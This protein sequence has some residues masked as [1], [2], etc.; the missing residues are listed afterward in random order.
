MSLFSILFIVCLFVWMNYFQKEQHVM[1]SA[2]V[3]G[4]TSESCYEDFVED[5]CDSSES[6]SPRYD[7][8]DLTT[9]LVRTQ[10]TRNNFPGAISV[11]QNEITCNQVE[12]HEVQG[13]DVTFKKGTQQELSNSKTVTTVRHAELGEVIGVELDSI[14]RN[15]CDSTVELANR[16]VTNDIMES[17]VG[18]D[19]EIL[20]HDMLTVKPT[21]LESHIKSHSIPAPAFITELDSLSDVEPDSSG[22]SGSYIELA[23]FS[24]HRL[25]VHKPKQR[26][27]LKD[28]SIAVFPSDSEM[29]SG[30]DDSLLD[31]DYMPEEVQN[32]SSSM[33]ISDSDSALRCQPNDECSVPEIRKWNCRKESLL[34]SN[35]QSKVGSHHSPVN[36]LET[37]LAKRSFSN[38]KHSV[39]E[40]ETL[41]RSDESLVV[42]NIQSKVDKHISLYV[43]ETPLADVGAGMNRNVD[44]VDHK[45]E[46]TVGVEKKGILLLKKKSVAVGKK[47]TYDK[48][49]YCIFCGTQIVSKI[50]RHLLSVHKNEEQVKEIKFL[51]K[52]SKERSVLLQKL[53]NDGNFEHNIAVIKEG[54]GQ[55]VVGRRTEVKGRTASQY[56][57][58]IYCRKWQSKT[59]LWRHSKTCRGS[60]EY[61]ESHPVGDNGKKPRVLAVKQ[62]QSLLSN[63]VYANEDHLEQLVNRMRDDEVKTIALADPLIRREAGL[64]LSALGRKIDQKQD[65]IYRV[66][67]SARM[68]GRVLLKARQTKPGISLT[69]LLV[70]SNF[71]CVVNIAKSMSTEK[72]DS[73]GPALNVGKSLGFLLKK[74]CESKYCNALRTYNC[75]QQAD[76]TN[77]TKLI[78]REWNSRVNR[79]ATRRIQNEKRNKLE[80]VPLTEDL[81]KFRNYLVTKIR[82]LSE[83]LKIKCNS[84]DWVMLAKCTMSRLILFNKR[85]RAEVR[86]L[87]VVEYLQRPDWKQNDCG[88]MAMALSPV[89]R[90]LA[91]R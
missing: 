6:S 5:S 31:P 66:S 24:D 84:K 75:Q 48:C 64:R 89:D 54:E 39:E 23:P 20:H 40:I 68:L 30:N 67:Q 19:E 69:D 77:F 56:T 13:I 17:N 60:T 25:Y 27:G 52:R 81:Q 51:P 82:E 74:V 15:E 59:N 16:I 44:E 12:V 38:E 79:S 8:C 28:V 42:S 87:K 33:G 46:T 36:V 35:N 86:E 18:S 50:Q 53:V 85:R 37:P 1:D 22:S 41:N 55:L 76:A 58:C 3:I 72:D 90:M 65:D 34:D 49:H 2:I 73:A 43:P 57:V 47:K 83:R 45:I 9:S 21:K 78:E 29:H 70:P 71:D 26:K 88:E 91:D 63:A 62:G 61:Y 80:A 7:Y 32:G 4:G 14:A 10:R 11:L